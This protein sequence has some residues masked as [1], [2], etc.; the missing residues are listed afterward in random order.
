M[1]TIF[2]AQKMDFVHIL[3][4]NFSKCFCSL[5]NS[6]WAAYKCPISINNYF[7]KLFFEMQT[8]DQV[9]YFVTD[10]M[11]QTNDDSFMTYFMQAPCFGYITI[12]EFLQCLIFVWQKMLWFQI[13]ARFFKFETQYCIKLTLNIY[14]F[15][16]MF[17]CHM[18]LVKR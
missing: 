7:G 13:R 10:I 9:V 3:I 4:S 14:V 16:L 5:L 12:K 18:Y 1:E 2:S 15:I 11:T 17:N 8:L 6:G